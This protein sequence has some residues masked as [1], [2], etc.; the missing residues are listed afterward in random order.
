MSKYFH[1]KRGNV[2]T[3]NGKLR[4]YYNNSAEVLEIDDAHDGDTYLLRVKNWK[5]EEQEIRAYSDEVWPITLEI[6]HL[7]R[8]GFKKDDDRNIFRKGSITVIRPIFRRTHPD[9][10]LIYDDRGFVVVE[11]YL[12]FPFTEEQVAEATTS[13]GSLH[14]FQNY[15][16]EKLKEPLS[17]NSFI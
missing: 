12:P 2:V 10:G 13:V 15:F 5:G 7:Q 17:A 14:A 8:A 6:D 11:K 16:G 1:I 4:E 9:G 3:Y